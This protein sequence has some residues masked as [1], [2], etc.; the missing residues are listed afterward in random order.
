MFLVMYSCRCEIINII[1]NKWYGF[2]LFGRWKTSEN[3]LRQYKWLKAEC[4]YLL[5]VALQRNSFSFEHHFIPKLMFHCCRPCI[6]WGTLTHCMP[7]E[8]EFYGRAVCWRL[9]NL[10]YVTL[11]LMH[12]DNHFGCANISTSLSQSSAV[13]FWKVTTSS[14]KETHYLFLFSCCCCWL[15][16]TFSTP[17]WWLKSNK[18]IDNSYNRI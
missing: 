2:K 1:N 3:I 16:C 7:A 5:N 6:L 17:L 14:S 4:G 9:P 18:I 11:T 13:I 12:L 8:E 10:W 15:P